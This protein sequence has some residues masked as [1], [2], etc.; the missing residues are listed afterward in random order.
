[1]HRIANFIYNQ[2][3]KLREEEKEKKKLKK[4]EKEI[5][6]GEQK[7]ERTCKLLQPRITMPGKQ[8]TG[9][10]INNKSVGSVKKRMA[11]NQMFALPPM[12]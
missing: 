9:L 6:G 8:T 12:W 7:G 5:E 1:M 11:T 4:R 3:E 2:R 10:L